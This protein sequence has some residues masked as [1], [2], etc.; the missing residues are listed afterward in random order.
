ME[1]QVGQELEI[2]LVK[3][4]DDTDE[5]GFERGPEALR[6]SDD[7]AFFAID[8]PA[9]LIPPKADTFE[10]TYRRSTFRVLRI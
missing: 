8:Q 2:I 4:A 7:R 5:A 1:D 9:A 10:I 3:R 6:F